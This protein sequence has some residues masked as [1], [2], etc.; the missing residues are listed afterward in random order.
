MISF[1]EKVKNFI[2]QYRLIEPGMIIVVG[3]SGGADSV[4]LLHV[5]KELMV[6][7]SGKL[8][9]AHLNHLLRPNAHEE[10][11]FVQGLAHQWGLPVTVG[12]CRVSHL[13]ARRKMGVEEAARLARYR[14][15]LQVARR[16]RAHRI[17]VGHHADDQVE[18]V[19]FNVIRG[20]GPAGLAGIPVRYGPVI[21][22]LLGVTKEEVEFYCR[23]AGLSWCIDPSNLESI[24]LRNKI[25]LE[26]LPFLRREFNPDINRAILRLASIME[27]ENRFL[28]KITRFLLRNLTKGQKAGEVDVLLQAFQRLPRALQRRVLRAAVCAAGGKLWNLSYQHIEDCLVLLLKRSGGGELHLPRGVR[29]RKGYDVFTIST[30]PEAIQEKREVFQELTIP[31]ETRVSP[32][33]LIF[34]TEIRPCVFLEETNY[35]SLPRGRYQAFF[36]Y[37]KIELP[38]YVRTRRSGDR[39]RL[40][41]LG[42]TKK[43]KKLFADLKIPRPVRDYIPL[44]A[45]EG[46][47]YWVVG[48]RRSEKAKVTKDSRWILVIKVSRK[49]EESW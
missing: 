3:V 12:Y 28:E 13:A 47:I 25:R 4:A 15:L 44:V 30:N 46:E 43:I 9:V 22:P 32:L 37:D 48:Y 41:G 10:A 19:L 33:G 40:L 36:D 21:R 7:F 18:T 20:T 35:L 23:G 1:Q 27:G 11:A 34:R 29:I 31:G 17:A 49:L 39:I 42:G 2:E 45:S 8:H 5:L 16:V 14:F 6:L 38:L 26:L 24:Y